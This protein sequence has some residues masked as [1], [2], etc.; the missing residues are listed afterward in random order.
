MFVNYVLIC[1][2]CC[3]ELCSVY[4][5]CMKCVDISFVFIATTL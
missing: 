3:V 2:V 4:S 5:I 1:S